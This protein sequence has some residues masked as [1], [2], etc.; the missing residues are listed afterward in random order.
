MYRDNDQAIPCLSA[1]KQQLDQMSN[2]EKWGCCGTTHAQA[3]A[4]LHVAYSYFL[5]RVPTIDIVV[6]HQAI[7]L[8][9][10]LVLVDILALLVCL[11]FQNQQYLNFLISRDAFLQLGV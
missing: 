11:L 4:S 6:Y 10:L 5:M 7:Q 1:Q 3:Y 9:S 8:H 2:Y